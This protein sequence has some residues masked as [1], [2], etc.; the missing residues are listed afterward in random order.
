MPQS[1]PRTCLCEPMVGMA[2]FLVMVVVGFAA[3]YAVGVSDRKPR[4]TRR[5]P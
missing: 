3:G 1:T 2:E 4:R 5:R